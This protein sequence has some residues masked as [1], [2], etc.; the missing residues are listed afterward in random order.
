MA[1]ETIVMSADRMKIMLSREEL[2]Q[3]RL[4][5]AELDTENERVQST[6]RRVIEEA[7]RQSGFDT[8]HSR[9]HVQ[10]YESKAGGCEMFV[11][12]LPREVWEE[13]E[14]MAVY[15]FAKRSDMIMLCRRLKNDGYEVPSAAYCLGDS[16]F[17]ILDGVEPCAACDYGVLADRALRPYIIEYGECLGACDAIAQLAAESP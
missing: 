14:E 6:L 13:V 17:L 11:T 5:G 3:Y 8:T 15:G 2:K 10:V 12:L 7:G 9:M 1:V 4:D 16:Y